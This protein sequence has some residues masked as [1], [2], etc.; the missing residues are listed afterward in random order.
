MRT[1]WYL[2]YCRELETK[3]APGGGYTAH[4]V[5]RPYARQGSEFLD[6]ARMRPGAGFR[7]AEGASG[8]G[9]SISCWTR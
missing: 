8:E 1:E 3:M 2:Q 5:A 6:Y 7:F 4:N 9:I